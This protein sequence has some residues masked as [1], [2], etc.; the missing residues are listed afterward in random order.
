MTYNMFGGM[1]NLAQLITDTDEPDIA[2]TI[3]KSISKIC[4]SDYCSTTVT[5]ITQQVHWKPQPVPSQCIKC[6]HNSHPSMAIGLTLGIQLQYTNDNDRH[7]HTNN[8]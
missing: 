3:A 6:K 4:S 5:G 2:Y 1:L 8:Q 7:R